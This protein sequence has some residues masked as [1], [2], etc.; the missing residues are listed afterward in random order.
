MIVKVSADS[1]YNVVQLLVTKYISRSMNI[2]TLLLFLFEQL[3]NQ[4]PAHLMTMINSTII[5]DND[6]FSIDIRDRIS[7]KLKAL[8]YTYKRKEASKP[9]KHF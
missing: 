6:I 7:A 9:G 3:G 8:A 5:T 2:R 1:P 4:I